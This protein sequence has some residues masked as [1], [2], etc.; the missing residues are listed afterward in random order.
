MFVKTVF[1]FK[2][3]II[4]FISITKKILTW[5]LSLIEWL[6]DYTE[7]RFGKKFWNN[8]FRKRELAKKN[9]ECGAICSACCKT[10]II[11]QNS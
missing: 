6:G 7:T 9:C 11:I 5:N 4:S 3:I 2:I 10:L 1:F 8:M